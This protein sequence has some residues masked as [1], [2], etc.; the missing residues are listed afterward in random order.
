M[1]HMTYFLKAELQKAKNDEPLYKSKWLEICLFEQ[2]LR[3]FKYHYHATV[4]SKKTHQQYV[5]F[6]AQDYYNNVIPNKI[7]EVSDLHII[8]YS[9]SRKVARETYL[10]AKV[11][12]GR[13][14]GL[15]PNGSFNFLGD[16]YQYDLLSRRPN[17]KLPTSP[18]KLPYYKCYLEPG[19]LKNSFLPSIGSYGVFYEDSNGE[20][21][22]AYQPANLLLCNGIR[23][24][25]GKFSMQTNIPTHG[26]PLRVPDLQ[27]TCSANV[28][29]YAVTHNLLGSPFRL[30][31]E[32]LYR[33]QYPWYWPPYIPMLYLANNPHFPLKLQNSLFGLNIQNG[34]SL[35]EIA[36]VLSGLSDF[37]DFI[38][39]NKE[40]FLKDNE[41]GADALS[42]YSEIDA[43]FD[44][45]DMSRA[46]GDQWNHGDEDQ[47]HYTGICRGAINL[48]LL[49]VDK[50][51]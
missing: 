44:E 30:T 31:R 29:E 4:I 21:D 5:G 9:P 19:F 7:K 27:Y 15:Q 8:S 26:T 23:G 11:A 38:I 1:K 36:E 2:M 42:R 12:R 48:I 14:N 47:N 20:M 3:T 35:R 37:R 13:N 40:I 22:F 51:C 6:D 39:D 43:H 28:F 34:N 17:V 16:W 25:E 32:R 41:Q 50:I 18:T 46:R 33:F 24:H 10:Q 45:T 49:N